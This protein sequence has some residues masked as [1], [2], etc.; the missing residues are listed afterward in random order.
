VSL[1]AL[2]RGSGPRFAR[3]MVGPVLAFYVVWKLAGLGAG[4]AAGS[5]TA[6]ALFAWERRRGRSGLGAS[7]GLGL[8]G[9]QAIVGMLSGSAIG[10]LA[11]PAIANGL[12]GLLFVGSVVIGRPLA[13]V[14]AAE[15]YPF[16]P[17][18]RTSSLFRRVFAIVSLAWG[19]ALLARCALRLLVLAQ[20]DVDLFVVVSVATGF[21]VNAA[22]IVWSFWYP[23]R[24]FRRVF[25]AV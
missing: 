22:L 25:A 19:L 6:V 16:P 18:I 9:V 17:E 24:R 11:P 5:A 12:Y 13:G 10:Y 3:D 1:R 15:T 2:L 21:P 4:I 14:F 7:F 8:A 20:G 23:L